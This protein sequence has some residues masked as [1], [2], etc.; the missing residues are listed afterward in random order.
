[1]T[2]EITV[3]VWLY[4]ALSKYAGPDTQGCYG[5]QQVAL[6][7]G[8]SMSDLLSRLGVPAKERG[9]TFINGLLS[10]MPGLQ[11]DLEH[12]LADGDRVGIFDTLSMWPFQYRHGASMTPEMAK[13]AGSLS[14][15]APSGSE[16]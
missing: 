12:V 2:A 14:H 16:S 15:S 4:G 1:M 10:A 5:S 8:S 9:L 7:K 6:P 11:P 3:E 13:A